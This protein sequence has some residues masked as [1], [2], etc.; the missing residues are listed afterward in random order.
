MH[1]HSLATAVPDATFTQPQ[2]WEIVKNS[3]VRQRLGRRSMLMLQAIL[4]GDSGVRQRHFAL[5]DVE[6]IFDLN[7]DELNAAFRVAAPSLA[8]KALEQALRRDGATVADLDALFVCTCTG[9][10]CPGVSSYVAEQMGV[11]PDAFI[12][13]VVGHGCGAAVPTMRAAQGFLAA[14]PGALV[15][16]VAV[17]I[18]SAAFYLDDDPGV[19]V[20]ACIFS[21]GAAAALWRSTP[22]L[23]QR[24][25]VSDFQTLHLPEA[26][27]LLR[28]EQRDGKLRNLLDVTVPSLAARVSRELLAVTTQR[29]TTA[30]SIV[31]PGGKDVI[32]AVEAELGI[33]MNS[34][35]TVLAENGNMSSPSVLFVLEHALRNSPPADNED[36]FLASFGAG[37]AA[38]SCRV[39]VAPAGD[40]MSSRLS[41]AVS[42]S[43]Q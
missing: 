20:S 33:R 5:P 15:A 42:S 11:R 28:F 14:N 1:L 18:C 35:R 26:R 36:W 22:S 34:S 43:V 19:I 9:Y 23:R 38:H 21:D 6:R 8:R 30:R 7:S 32:E 31:H 17:E 2:C 4:R 40:A 13:D 10:L 29:G 3:S 24:I 12:F 27:D 25:E 41:P 39:S 37:F 16:T